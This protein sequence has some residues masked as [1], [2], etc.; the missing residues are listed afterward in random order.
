MA[1]TSLPIDSR[2]PSTANAVRAAIACI[3]LAVPFL[4]PLSISPIPTFVNQWWAVWGMAWLVVAVSLHGWSTGTAP[5]GATGRGWVGVWLALAL[6]Q[7]WTT[8]PLGQRGVPFGTLMLAAAATWV[9]ARSVRARGSEACGPKP[10]LRVGE[11]V[12]LALLLAALLSA[13]IG[14]VQVFAPTWADGHWMAVPTL[15]G[16]AIGNLRQPNQLST[17][18]LW[19]CGAAVWLGVVRRWAWG[20]T[21]AAVLVLVL[22]NALT[23]SR[24]GMVGVGLM[25]L[26]GA[27]DRRLPGRI[28][29]L[30]VAS[31]A[32][33]GLG[34][35]GLEEWSRQ[36][37]Q[38]F[39]GD[40]QIKKSLHGDLTSSRGKVWRDTWT[41]IEQHPWTGVGAGAYNFA[42]SMTAFPGRAIAFFDHS[43]NLPMQLAVES[44]LPFAVLVLVTLAWLAWRAGR[45]WFVPD[46][47]SARSARV[48][49]FML[50]I[51]AVHS[52][53]E[54]PLW[55]TYFLLPTAVLTGWLGALDPRKPV[56]ET[57]GASTEGASVARREWAPTLMASVGAVMLV[58]CVWAA[59]QFHA[60]ATI[61]EPDLSFGTPAP[62]EDR[63]RRGQASPLFGHHADYAHVT[64]A[65]HPERQAREFDRPLFHLLDS[66]IMIAYAR[67]LAAEG[68]LPRANHVAARLREFN[69][70]ASAEFFEPCRDDPLRREFP[71]APDPALAAA[72]L[73]P[74][75]AFPSGKSGSG[76]V[77]PSTPGASALH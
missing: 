11:P 2:E 22:A 71:C 57:G 34:W 9:M 53:L 32:I 75:V 44:G 51:I 64:M 12:M 8:A 19:G 50:L 26:W 25:A 65:A 4:L 47:A 15:P 21:A 69:N 66:R 30:L 70:P 73:R 31:V 36:H 42:W 43:H 67:A 68:D 1:L 38:F 41:L 72:E 40:D 33:Y 56:D 27:L 14:A 48:L 6:S 74:E 61:F 37:G 63:I 55:Y 20:W 76:P 16:R 13:A 46:D 39:Y 5:V 45:A 28:R 60:V 58:A 59:L 49:S 7:V 29:L 10:L 52:M 23:V 24:T 77:A 62:L 17:L 54:Y 18:L 3:C 35:W